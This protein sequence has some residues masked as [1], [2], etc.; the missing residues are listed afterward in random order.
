MNQTI[1]NLILFIMLIGVGSQVV[2]AQKRGAR[3]WAT[4]NFNK[5]EV[6]VGE[7][8]VVTVMVYTSTW[9]TQP[10]IFGE[11]QVPN[12]LMVRLQ[13]RTGSKMVT[14][15]RKQ[16]PAIQQK[17]VVYPRRTGEN[18]LP[19]F[20]V[21]VECPPEGGYKG[22]KRVVK[23]KERIFTVLPPPEGMDT[24]NWLTAYDVDITDTW[25]KPLKDL[26]AGDVL[27]RRLTINASGALAASIP[28]LS[29]DS[30][31][32]GSVY[33]KKPQL[34]NRQNASSFSGTRT[35]ILTYLIEKDGDFIIPTVEV[36]WYS[37]KTKKIIS[38]KIDSI[39]ISVVE[40]PN[41]EFIL[42]Q[43]KALQ[44][45]LALENEAVED[46]SEPFELY[47]LN[48]WQLLLVVIVLI[49][50][51]PILYRF[52]KQISIK[53]T[54]RH[55]QNLESE[56]HYFKLLLESVDQDSNKDIIK[57]LLFWYD[58]FRG[59]KYGVQMRTFAAEVNQPELSSNLRDL[60]QQ[61]Y[62][63][64]DIDNSPS[65]K[66]ALKKSLIKARNSSKKLSELQQNMKWNKLN[67]Q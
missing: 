14:I 47:G 59:H 32:F 46:I 3:I 63:L 56:S 48:W 60:S 41:L 40:N 49:S 15:A 7:P 10:P 44:D 8:L 19:A 24:K 21:T 25:D 45:Q 37:L 16:Y 5:Q 33:H 12:A 61:T 42:S 50:I 54:E 51:V 6:M 64:D 36:N 2:Q 62:K 22:V 20:E 11:I 18:I 30:I 39:P 58:R 43:Q 67:P 26:K 34:N 57:K 28:P 29:F 9:F 65:S 52:I 4:A 55:K 27:E 53:R 23:T 66:D 38:K 17:F 31:A 35:E 1:R 13:Q